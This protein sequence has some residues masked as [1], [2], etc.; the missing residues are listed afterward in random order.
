MSNELSINLCD[1]LNTF[2]KT[3]SPCTNKCHSEF[4]TGNHHSK[5]DKLTETLECGATAAIGIIAGFWT[6]GLASVGAF[7]AGIVCMGFRVYEHH[8]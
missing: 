6:G 7:A 8:R 5:G 2:G 1:S 4:H 3:T